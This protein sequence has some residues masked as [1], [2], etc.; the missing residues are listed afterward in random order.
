MSNAVSRETL[1]NLLMQFIPCQGNSMYQIVIC[2]SATAALERD[3]PDLE[4]GV[5]LS[6]I[7]IDIMHVIHTLIQY[8]SKKK[9][10]YR[11]ADTYIT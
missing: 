8:P 2:R 11:I 5:G 7:R 1:Y 6:R 10:Y 3:I 4:K 9:Y